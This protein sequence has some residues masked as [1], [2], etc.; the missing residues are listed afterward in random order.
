[1]DPST[2]LEPSPTT[3]IAEEP[4]RPVVAPQTASGGC[5]CGGSKGPEPMPMASSY[6]YALG[7]IEPRYASL[8]V[9]KEF[10]QATGRADTKGLTDRQALHKILCKKENRYLA[11]Q[12]CWVFTV[13]G[14]ET[15]LLRPRDPADIDL[16]VEALRP[17]PRASDIDVVIGVRGPVVPPEFCNGLTV[18]L[19]AFDQIYSFDT[20]AL[21]KTVPRPEKTSDEKFAPDR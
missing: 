3:F 19:V 13:T 17:A 9:E 2:P 4:S 1:M 6:V 10:A 21:I 11:R 14:L 15:Y 12:L 18:P 8:A 16:L 5:A 20:D 7:Q